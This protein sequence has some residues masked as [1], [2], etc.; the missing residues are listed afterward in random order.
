MTFVRELHECRRNF[1]MSRT[2]REGFEHVQKFY[3]IFFLLK[4]VIRLLCDSRMTFVL[5]LQTCLREIL[6]IYNT[7][8][9]QHLYECHT[10]VA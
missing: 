2:N 4:C 1:H 7:K 8:I 6:A 9:S 10:T 3:A 5:V